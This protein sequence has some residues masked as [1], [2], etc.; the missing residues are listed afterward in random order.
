MSGYMAGV[1]KK[2]IDLVSRI[3]GL[4]NQLTA[5]DFEDT[6]VTLRV[7]IMEEDLSR[8][9]GFW[10]NEYNFGN[11]AFFDGARSDIEARKS[12]NT[13]VSAL[14]DRLRAFATDCVTN[15]D[16]TPTAA[17]MLERI[18]EEH[19]SKKQS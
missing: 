6:Y 9:L 5:E 8:E 19:E 3:T 1:T 7:S 4:L 2:G 15:G 18:L 11:W 16:M 17:R 14:E 10:S 13:E 12:D